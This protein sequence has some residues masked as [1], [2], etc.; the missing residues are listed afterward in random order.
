[1]KGKDLKPHIGI[2]GRRNYGK[3]SLINLLAG[4]DVAIV[5]EH[6]GTTT[7]PVKKSIEIFGIGPVIMV[8]TA[9]IDDSGDLGDKRV[10]R[11]RQ[12]LPT[13]DA[14]I[15]VLAHNQFDEEELELI[16]QL[17]SFDVPYLILHQ[18]SDL[19]ILQSQTLQ[20]IR[21]NTEAPVLE[22]NTFDL[23]MRDHIIERLKQI[24]PTTAFVKPQLLAGMIKPKDVVLLVTPIDLAAPEG[25]MILPQVMTLR[26]VLDHD[27]ICV[28]VKDSELEDFLKTGIK[29]ALVVTDS[30]AFDFVSKLVPEDVPLTGFS[31]IFARMKGDFDAYLKGTPKLSNL[32]DGDKILMLESCTHQVTCDDIG[33]VKLPNWIKKFSGKNIEFDFISGIA[34]LPVD[35]SKYA[36]IIQCGG[37]MVTRK[38]VVNRIKMAAQQGV[39][40]TNYGLAIAYLNGIFDRVVGPMRSIS[41]P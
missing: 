38:Q 41:T 34:P 26:D 17:N 3:S 6:A 33:R 19:E 32:K 1:M 8:D 9:G 11:T 28:T 30:Q 15:L 14:A 5:S 21:S 10:E 22:T 12:V 2:F 24:V 20:K 37:C 31:I 25:R 39:A 27:A 29:P 23:S 18:K 35:L 16:Q 40:V 4:Q 13:L 36:L 7:D